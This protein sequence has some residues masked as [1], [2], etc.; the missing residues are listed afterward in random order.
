MIIKL[1]AA[2]VLLHID[3]DEVLLF[4]KGRQLF[5]KLFFFD[6]RNRR[7][8]RILPGAFPCTAIYCLTVQRRWR[9]VKPP[10]P[11]AGR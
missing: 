10:V 5:E 1:L 3:D 6:G 9:N 7:R 8:I 2:H 11:S 4:K